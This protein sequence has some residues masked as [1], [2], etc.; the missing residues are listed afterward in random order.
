[1]NLGAHCV[2]WV[3][4]VYKASVQHIGEEHTHT[5]THTHTQEAYTWVVNPSKSTLSL[6]NVEDLVFITID[7]V[8]QS[9]LQGG[10]E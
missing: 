2:R 8:K 7:G 1:M 6:P 10:E 3:V 9:E 5:H 4:G